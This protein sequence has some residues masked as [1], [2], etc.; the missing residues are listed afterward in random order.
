MEVTFHGAAGVFVAGHVTEERRLVLV[1][2]P[3]LRQQ[4]VVKTAQS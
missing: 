2:A 4:T 1:I 3:I